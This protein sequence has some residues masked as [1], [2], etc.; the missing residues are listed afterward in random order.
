M[1]IYLTEMKVHA[2]DES[3]LQLLLEMGK[4]SWPN[5][6]MVLLGAEKGI[7]NEVYPVAG[8]GGGKDASYIMMDM[9][10]LGMKFVG[11]AHSHPC[12]GPIQPS[13]TDYASFAEMGDIHI[14]V[15]EPFDETA[16]RAFNREGNIISL[17]I[18]P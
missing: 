5:E 13:D 18:S 12:S 16:W 15:G 11:T 6:Y 7:I 8:S 17:N 9:F 1:Q 2:I 4:S 10:P 14:I 3:T